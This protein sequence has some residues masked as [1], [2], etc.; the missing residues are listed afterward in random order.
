MLGIGYGVAVSVFSVITYYCALMALTLFYMVASF[1]SV[2][3][4]A[5]CW[6]EWG[7]GCFD[8]S[9]AN[10]TVRNGSGSSAEF[11]FRYGN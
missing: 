11:Y 10:G 6:E 7:S 5:F 2:L 8:S 1:Q 3:P 4:W 9:S